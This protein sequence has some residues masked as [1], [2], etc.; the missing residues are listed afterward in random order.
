M[1]ILWNKCIRTN[2]D[3]LCFIKIK[4]LQHRSVCEKIN[5]SYLHKV[6]KLIL[7]KVNKFC[8]LAPHAEK[9][10]L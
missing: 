3:K 5:Y 6:A 4:K 7:Q 2:W 9:M 1:S 8:K 10:F